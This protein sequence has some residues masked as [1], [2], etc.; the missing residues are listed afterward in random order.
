[1]RARI[2]KLGGLEPYITTPDEFERLLSSEYSKY[3]EVVKAAGAKV[4]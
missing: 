3:A 2:R 4:D 1:M